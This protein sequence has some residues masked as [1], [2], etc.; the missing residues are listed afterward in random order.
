MDVTSDLQCTGNSV[1]FIEGCQ[2][3][4]ADRHRGSEDDDDG[5]PIYRSR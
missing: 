1:S 3:Y 4:V 5:N 2:A